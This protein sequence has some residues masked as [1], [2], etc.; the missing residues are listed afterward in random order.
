MLEEGFFATSIEDESI[1]DEIDATAEV[2]RVKALV[3]SGS[4]VESVIELIEKSYS[5]ETENWTDYGLGIM[6]DTEGVIKVALI[7]GN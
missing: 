1:F 4:K 2:S 5:Q 7:W 3:V 6:I